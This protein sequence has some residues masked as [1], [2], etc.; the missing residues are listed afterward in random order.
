MS[1]STSLTVIKHNTVVKLFP[2]LYF[3]LNTSK[4][5][6]SNFSYFSMLIILPLQALMRKYPNGVIP[7]NARSTTGLVWPEQ[8]SGVCLIAMMETN[9][10]E[11]KKKKRKKR[12]K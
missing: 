3:S 2:L 5:S 6:D 8:V 10:K 7:L 4:D 11:K 1:H 12:A 9:K